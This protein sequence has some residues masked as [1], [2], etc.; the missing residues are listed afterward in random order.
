MMQR[1]ATRDGGG[2]YVSEQQLTGLSDHC[3]SLAEGTE[4]CNY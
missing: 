3:E 4:L 1:E 2:N